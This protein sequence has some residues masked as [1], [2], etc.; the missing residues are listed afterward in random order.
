MMLYLRL[1]ILIRNVCDVEAEREEREWV[2]ASIAA[3]NGNISFCMATEN[4]ISKERKNT[5]FFQLF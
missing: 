1:V 2:S 4:N 3:I 5:D